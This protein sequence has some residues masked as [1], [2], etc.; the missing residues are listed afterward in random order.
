[1]KKILL[2]TALVLLSVSS[3]LKFENEASVKPVT[4]SAPTIEISAVGDSTFTA[5][6]TPAAGTNFYSYAVLEGKA[7][8]VSATSLLSVKVGSNI[9]EG[10]S[11]VTKEASKKIVAVKLMPDTDYTVY[12]VATS[13]QGQ[14]TEVTAVET[15]TSDGLVPTLTKKESKDGAATLTFSEKVKLNK[16][17]KAYATY[18]KVNSPKDDTT[19]VVPHDKISI[20]DNV[21]T[22]PVIDTIPGAYVV[23]TWEKGLFKDSVDSLAA[24][25]DVN[26]FEVED[27]EVDLGKSLG[28]RIPTVAWDF[29]W[30]DEN[31]DGDTL[32]YFADPDALA[33]T[34]Y[35]KGKKLTMNEDAEWIVR[36]NQKHEGTE[37]LYPIETNLDYSMVK[38]T[39]FFTFGLEEA[40]EYTSVLDFSIAEGAFT[41]VYGNPNNAFERESAYMRLLASTGI[42]G[43]YAYTYNGDK[44]SIY[45]EK[46]DDENVLVYAMDPELAAIGGLLGQPAY[47]PV[48]GK[49][50]S[51][52]GTVTISF[53]Q[54]YNTLDLSL[55]IPSLTDPIDFFLLTFDEEGYLTDKGSIVFDV[56]E[57]GCLE[58]TALYAIANPKLGWLTDPIEFEDQLFIKMSNTFEAPT[59]S[60]A[61]AS[62]VVKSNYVELRK[63]K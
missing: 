39:T 27:G 9:A 63:F 33:P 15:H 10:Y 61:K 20:K 37:Y 29:T 2:Y 3:C 24:G 50:D 42:E 57:N 13:E 4:T 14:V 31:E 30:T 38:D 11:D 40:P 44:Y 46:V 51:E 48:K 47:G 6:V 45:F 36:V 12:A 43:E 58:C 18:Y 56:L 55:L 1:M 23:Y 16:E 22:F 35:I 25:N 41:D 59:A 32:I 54:E 5:T 19:I 17:A 52:E 21:V 7:K 34:L 26:T 8:S 49:Y 28:S 62:H 60:A 53:G